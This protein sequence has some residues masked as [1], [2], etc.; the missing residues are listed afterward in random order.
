MRFSFY[1]WVDRML[2]FVFCFVLFCFVL[3]LFFVFYLFFVMQITQLHVGKTRQGQQQVNY[4]IMILGPHKVATGRCPSPSTLSASLVPSREH[5]T[6]AG[7][8]NCQIKHFLEIWNSIWRSKDKRE[9]GLLFLLDT[10]FERQEMEKG[11]SK[12]QLRY[13][14]GSQ[15]VCSKEIRFLVLY[16]ISHVARRRGPVPA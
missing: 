14:P 4:L 10:N 12:W 6:K 16:I 2:G 9:E 8:S 13:Q 7:L 3:F 5:S 1:S 15:V 11:S